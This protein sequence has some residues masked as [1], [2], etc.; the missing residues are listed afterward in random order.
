MCYWKSFNPPCASLFEFNQWP[1]NFR[2]TIRYNYARILE[3]PS[4]QPFCSFSHLRWFD[5]WCARLFRLWCTARNTWRMADYYKRVLEQNQI[6]KKTHTH[7]SS[8]TCHW[9][10]SFLCSAVG[11]F[12]VRIYFRT[13]SPHVCTGERLTR[14]PYANSWHNIYSVKSNQVVYVCVCVCSRMCAANM[15]NAGPVLLNGEHARICAELCAELCT[16]LEGV[17]RDAR[18]GIFYYFTFLKPSINFGRNVV[19]GTHRKYLR[20]VNGVRFLCVKRVES[21]S[22]GRR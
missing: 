21:L 10:R 11:G 2:P 13:K 18:T 19:I 17:E 8:H 3:D 15:F 6:H 7:T 16:F 5:E 20:P 12:Y 14:A 1:Q 9:R 4:R 22:T